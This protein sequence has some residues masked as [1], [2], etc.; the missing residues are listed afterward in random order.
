MVGK[1][2][3]LLLVS[4]DRCCLPTAHQDNTIMYDTMTEL[5]IST[6]YPWM[7]YVGG[8]DFVLRK[9]S[10]R[11]KALTSVESHQLNLLDGLM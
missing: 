7:L 5:L 3:G 11:G 9:D 2:A 1:A 8:I 6:I 10:H 4:I